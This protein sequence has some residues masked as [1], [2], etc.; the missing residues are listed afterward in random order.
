MKEQPFFLEAW[1]DALI[2]SLNEFAAGDGAALLALLR[3]S[4]MRHEYRSILLATPAE[5]PVWQ[6]P[7]CEPP[8]P[9]R[10]TGAA[11]DL[12]RAIEAQEAAAAAVAEIAGYLQGR[13]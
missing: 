6:V 9:I 4:P 5:L 12:I 11:H 7:H 3:D 8:D 1:F 10:R 2:H 13:S